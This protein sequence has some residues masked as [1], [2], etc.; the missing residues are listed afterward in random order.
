MD[1]KE[2]IKSSPMTSFQVRAIAIC[3]LLN[4]VDGYDVIIMPLSAPQ[5]AA[6]FGVD[7]VLLGYLLSSSLIGMTIGAFA[8]APISDFLGRRNV[9]L[10][11]LILAT[12]GMAIGALSPNLTVLFVSR[13]IAGIGVGG[14]VANLSVTVSEYSNRKHAALATGIYAAGYPVG[15]TLGGALA[16]VII[17]N[18]GWREGFWLGCFITAALLVACVFLLPESYD[19]LIHKGGAKNKERLNKILPKMGQQPVERLPEVPKGE[20]TKLGDLFKGVFGNGMWMQTL[21]AWIGYALISSSFYFANSW[22]T[23]IVADSAGDSNLGVTANVL[24]NAGGIF[25]SAIFGLIAIKIM[26]R[27]LLGL[28]MIFGAATYFLFGF[29]LNQ[30]FAMMLVGMLAGMAAVAG[31][32][33]IYLIGPPLYPTKVRGAG[34]GWL[35]GIGR[36]ASIAA[37]IIVGYVLAAG[38][39]AAN[40]YQMFAVPLLLAGVAF[41]LLGIVRKKQGF[42][43]E[44]T[45]ESQN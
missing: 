21:L 44:P 31:V 34:F 24:Y 1:L 43:P 35:M 5:V 27:R 22:T 8:L 45:H 17:A 20:E 12:A 36:L 14:M 37:P 41:W 30:T 9:M 32:A 16:G 3:F 26:P 13:I 28:T 4:M 11:A 29:F 33:G 38:V 25:G 10:I 6:E 42:N 18:T 7:D 40:V 15:A 39:E 2:R 19:Y 23:K